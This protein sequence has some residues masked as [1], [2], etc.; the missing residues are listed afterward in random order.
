MLR[1]KARRVSFAEQVAASDWLRSIAGEQK[2]IE[3]D[4]QVQLAGDLAEAIGR[5]R[6][7]IAE[8]TLARIAA[9]AGVTLSRKGR[10]DVDLLQKRIDVLMERVVK[11]EEAVLDL[12]IAQETASEDKKVSQH[13]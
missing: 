1:A 7:E 13:D 3:Y 12:E 5:R 2:I 4:T 8:M 11:L 6:G 9:A 10:M